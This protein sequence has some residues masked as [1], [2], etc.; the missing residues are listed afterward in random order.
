MRRNR[1]MVAS[2]KNAP[3]RISQGQTSEEFVFEEKSASVPRL[4]PRYPL[5]TSPIKTLAGGQFQARKPRL[6]AHSINESCAPLSDSSRSKR[7][8]PSPLTQTA[9]MPANPSMPSMKLKR[10]VS[11]T[12]AANAVHLRT[13]PQRSPSPNCALPIAS[14]HQTAHAAASE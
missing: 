13:Q 2:A 8:A 12:N 11:Q 9:S 1:V 5:P 6:A 10:L 3:S 7:N 4:K 14:T